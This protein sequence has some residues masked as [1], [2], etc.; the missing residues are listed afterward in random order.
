MLRFGPSFR[1]PPVLF[2]GKY[3]LPIANVK[4]SLETDL[5]GNLCDS[6][7]SLGYKLPMSFEGMYSSVLPA[8]ALCR[9]VTQATATAARTTGSTL[10]SLTI[11]TIQR[12]KPGRQSFG[13][14]N[15]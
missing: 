15:R 13:I 5:R 6:V 12:A 3:T 4:P 8:I 9:Y 11:N 7:T 1:R 14:S 2:Q 10:T